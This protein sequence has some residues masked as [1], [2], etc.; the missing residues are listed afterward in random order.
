MTL[1]AVRKMGFTPP[2]GRAR[3]AVETGGSEGC[4]LTD[5]PGLIVVPDLKATRY[6]KRAANHRAMVVR[7]AD[8][9]W[10]TA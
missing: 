8:D 4:I 1:G 5:E 9:L 3:Q 2:Y 10:L 6:E 7:R